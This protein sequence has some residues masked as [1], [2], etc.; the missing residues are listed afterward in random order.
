MAK[1]SKRI[2]ITVFKKIF[3]IFITDT[4]HFPSTK[5]P[6]SKVMSFLTIVSEI[7]HKHRQTKIVTCH[8]N[9]SVSCSSYLKTYFD[10][11]PHQ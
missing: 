8:I 6:L 5:K 10:I 2:I 4:F 9:F 3:Y 11:I 1:N 7:L